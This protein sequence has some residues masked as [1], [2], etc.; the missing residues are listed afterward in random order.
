MMTAA[1]APMNFGF[2]PIRTAPN[3]V[4]SP[5]SIRTRGV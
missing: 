3:C 1:K 2:S 4:L 5:E